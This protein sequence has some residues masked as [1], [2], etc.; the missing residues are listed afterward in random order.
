MKKKSAVVYV[1]TAEAKTEII[2]Y[3]TLSASSVPL[4]DFPDEATKKLS[5]YPNV[6]VTL[7]GRL[8]VDMK[9]R[10]EGYE[11]KLLIEALRM[12]Y[13]NSLRVAS[14]AVVVDAKADE[15]VAFYKKFGFISFT[16]RPQQLFLPIK[17]V[18]RLMAIKH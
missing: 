18:E 15:S 17:T 3:Y 14:T 10:G 16:T 5:K 2:G 13:E 8:A 12:S 4:D 9:H 11:E 7:M 1:L 6:P